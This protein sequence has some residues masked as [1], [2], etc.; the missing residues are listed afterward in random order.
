MVCLF[1]QRAVQRNNIGFTEQFI[2]FHIV[3]S[4]VGN[5]ELVVS[6]DIHTETLAD[7]SENASDFAGADDA[8]GL[9]VQIEA[10]KACKTEVKLAGAEITVKG[11]K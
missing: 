2:Q 3:Q 10:G 7:I 5:G 4:A 8:D 1:C 11:P 6:Q 9:A